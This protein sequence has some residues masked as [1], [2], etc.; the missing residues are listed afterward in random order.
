MR[1]PVQ[2]ILV[3]AALLIAAGAP[4]ATAGP[5]SLSDDELAEVT[6]GEFAVSL[7]GFDVVIQDNQAGTFTLDIA[8]SA[9]DSAQGVFT[10]LQAINSAVNL[11]VIVNIY[12]NNNSSI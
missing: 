4:S 11:S 9:F 12:L 10:T 8:Q 6:A 2:S 7:D 3:A 5:A 1:R